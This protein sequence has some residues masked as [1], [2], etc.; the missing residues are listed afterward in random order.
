MTFDPVPWAVRNAAVSAE[1]GRLLAHLAA[2]GRPGVLGAADLKVRAL[3]P[4]SGG[5]VI[6]KGAGAAL[7]R[8]AGAD[9]GQQSYLVRNPGDHGP[10]PITATPAGA[11]R[12]D[13]IAVVIEDPFYAGQPAPVDVLNGPYVHVRVYEGVP[14]ATTTL[15]EV[16]PG[17]AGL[18][19]ARIDIPAGTAT[20]TDA[21]V[22]NLRGLLTARSQSFLQ[23]TNPSG[24]NNMPTG[25]YA[26]WTAP[27][28][29]D[30]PPWANRVTLAAAVAGAYYSAPSAAGGILVRLGTL[31]TQGVAFDV[32]TS[33]GTDRI[34]T[35]MAGESG[36]VI[37]AGMRGTR[38]Q[39]AV[40]AWKTAGSNVV[41][42]HNV[43]VRLEAVFSEAPE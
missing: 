17:Q 38:Q 13:L 34:Q 3:A 24:V 18:A 8:F 5:V 43:A 32:A 23:V 31:L 27:V 42:D 39:L 37:P 7:N 11:A 2:G 4:N 14:A 1:T 21:M 26:D 6:G 41:A 22:K 28:L 10:I 29:V 16:D 30:V 20:I 36:V 33:A 40:R 9:G 35:L 12:S 19:L 25:G 15:E